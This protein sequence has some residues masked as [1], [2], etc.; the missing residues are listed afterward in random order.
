M[1]S[2]KSF[3]PVLFV[4]FLAL[5][6]LAFAHPHM[7]LTSSCEFVWKG[8]V[9]SGVYIDW[10]F[11]AYFSADIIRGYDANQD[12]KFNAAETKAVYD[13]AFQNL[14]KYY[15]FTFIRQGDTRTNPKS[16]SDFSAYQSGSTLHYRFFIDLSGYKGEL[17]I[18]V[19]DYTYFCAIEY[20][21]ANP[22]ILR[23]DDAAIKP[24]FSIAENHQ[25]PVYYNPL[26]AVDDTTIYY[27]WKKGLITFYP[28]EI[29][30]SY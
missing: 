15:F 7:S 23:F 13:N 1:R 14:R 26:G 22:V 10:A 24:A 6:S 16:V 30:V 2:A 3:L 9:L 5:P 29:H 8:P 21:K 17:W 19:Y 12:G 20:D 4:L 27:A 18:A 28:R 25:Y 11:D